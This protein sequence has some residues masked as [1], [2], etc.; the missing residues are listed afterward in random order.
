MNFVMILLAI[1]GAIYDRRYKKAGGK[2][3]TKNEKGLFAI[4]CLAIVALLITL[5][6]LGA[7]AESL[8]EVTVYLAILMFALWE[9]GRW[10]VRRRN[11]VVVLQT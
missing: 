2:R 8:G 7:S 1:V 9:L 6:V 5:A 3:A 10:R 4:V 11:P